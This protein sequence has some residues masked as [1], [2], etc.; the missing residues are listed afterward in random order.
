MQTL[1]KCLFIRNRQTESSHPCS[2]PTPAKLSHSKYSNCLNPVIL[3][4]FCEIIKYLKKLV[5]PK[6]LIHKF[7]CVTLKHNPKMFTDCNRLFV[8]PN[9]HTIRSPMVSWALFSLTPT[10]NLLWFKSKQKPS[11]YNDSHIVQE[12]VLKTN[13]TGYLSY[14]TND[15]SSCPNPKD[16]SQ[17]LSF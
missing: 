7:I 10:R 15:N 8:F 3:A 13:T 11:R 2:L 1:K 17:Q 16:T 12:L 14:G 4:I 5:Q 9:S 6:I